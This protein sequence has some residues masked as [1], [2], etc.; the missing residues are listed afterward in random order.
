VISHL[1]PLTRGR[2]TG[3]GPKKHFS[4]TAFSLCAGALLIAAGCSSGT[5]TAPPPKTA[6][7]AISLAVSQTRQVRSL[8]ESFNLRNY[9]VGTTTTGTMREQAQPTQVLDAANVTK[10][11]S[12][13]VTLDE[14]LTSKAIYL[15]STALDMWSMVPLSQVTPANQ[16]AIWPGF[17][18]TIEPLIQTRMLAVA[19][20]ARAAGQQTIDGIQT[21]QYQGSY[22]PTAAIAELPATVARVLGPYLNSLIGTVSFSVWIDAQHQVRKLQFTNSTRSERETFTLSVTSVNQPVGNLVPPASRVSTIPAS[23]LESGGP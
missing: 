3:S 16:L 21:T 2:L 8:T 19:T 9:T 4:V 20:N 17:L 12:G 13:P 6:A 7:Q 10:T 5:A 22:R 14:L 18:E 1:P 15:R 23:A 11:S